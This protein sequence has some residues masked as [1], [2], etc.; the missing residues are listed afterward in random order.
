MKKKTAKTTKKKSPVKKSIFHKLLNS[1]MVLYLVFLVTCISIFN[2]IITKNDESLFLFIL[3]S[4]I[5]YEFNGN[6]ILILGIP[7]GI[8]NLLLYLKNIFREGLI[9]KDGVNIKSMLIKSIVSR[10]ER[11]HRKIV[12][13]ALKNYFG[14]K[15]F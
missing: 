10:E 13:T 6:M 9:P 4:I 15:Y 2:F 3:I 14:T 7:L 12:R 8:V 5:I 1:T 11:A